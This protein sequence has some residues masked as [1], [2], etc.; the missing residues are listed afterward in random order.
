MYVQTSL[1]ITSIGR[2]LINRK[3]CLCYVI[4]LSFGQ[5]KSKRVNVTFLLIQKQLYTQII[6]PFYLFIF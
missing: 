2:K 5:R 6:Y 1:L 4:L 3:I